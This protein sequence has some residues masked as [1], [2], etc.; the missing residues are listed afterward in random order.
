MFRQLATIGIGLWLAVGQALAV[1][2]PEPELNAVWRLYRHHQLTAAQTLWQQWQRQHPPGFNG[3]LFEALLAIQPG[4]PARL[5][6]TRQLLDS[7]K[8]QG[9]SSPFYHFVAGNYWLRKR[10]WGAAIRAFREAVTLDPL[11]AE[12]YAGLGKAYLEQMLEYRDRVTPHE[13][14]LSFAPFAEKDFQHARENL[15]TALRLKPDLTDALF[16]LGLLYY[17]WDEP[18]SMIALFKK[19]CEQYPQEVNFWLFLGLGY[20]EQ[21]EYARAATCFDR[22]LRLM[23][24]ETRKQFTSP[25]KLRNEFVQ[26]ALHGTPE[27]FWAQNDPLYLTPEN[28]FQQ[29]FL[30]RLAYVNLRFGA[31]AVGLKGWQTD[32][33]QAYLFLGKPLRIIR[34]GKSFE[35]GSI[36]PPAE[37]WVYREF[38]L[39]FEDTFWNGQFQL[40]NPELSSEGV[41]NFRSRS[42]VDFTIVARRVFKEHQ[43]LMDIRFPGGQL[44]LK[45]YFARFW[46]KRW[47]RPEVFVALEIPYQAFQALDSLH[48][49]MGWYLRDSIP[50]QLYLGE[51]NP[52][53]YQQ[54]HFPRWR[55]FL[56][57]FRVPVKPAHFAYSLE[58][59][60]TVHRQGV[61]VRD[62]LHF[63]EISPEKFSMSDI[64][65]AHYLG[66]DARKGVPFRHNLFIDPA[67]SYR[68]SQK[69]PINLYFE[70]Y[71]LK[72]AS[73]NKA[74]YVIENSLVPVKSSIW[75]RIW[76]ETQGAI[77]VVNEYEIFGTT[78]YVHQQLDVSG[79]PA[80]DYRLIIKATDLISGAEQIRE[81]RVT[82]EN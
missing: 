73:D 45:A 40:A 39:M 57:A 53:A 35:E 51:I 25:K 71:N 8:W 59:L 18:D 31:P 14:P 79:L 6:R 63:P 2:F 75:K 50:R 17:E 20:Q 38:S 32:R 11:F 66:P 41:S 58:V 44:T 62:S 1:V 13:V 22:A 36:F 42:R 80:G 81:T 21:Q 69:N 64:V 7:L 60:E 23:P 5:F 37:L 16:H 77:T 33:G 65:L 47:Q 56:Y 28:E 46:D 78:D 43:H 3:R 61:V 82:I 19:A 9:Q 74:T 52:I 68:F 12:A 54:A 67:F 49:R 10:A 30:A 34:Y 70:L 76:G 26:V 29:E 72:Q 27:R 55:R 15:Q 24:L 4:H 48:L